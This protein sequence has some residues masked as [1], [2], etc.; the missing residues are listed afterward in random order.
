MMSEGVCVCVRV[1]VYTSSLNS[2]HTLLHKLRNSG[3]LAV[4]QRVQVTAEDIVCTETRQ[5]GRW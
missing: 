5:S 2:S 1:C 4:T 3:V